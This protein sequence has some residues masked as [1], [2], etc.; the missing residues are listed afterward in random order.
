MHSV[1]RPQKHASHRQGATKKYVR[2][3]RLPSRVAHLSV[4][5]LG[6][7][8]LL[9]IHFTTSMLVATTCH[10]TSGHR[11]N[12]GRIINGGK[13]N[14]TKHAEVPHVHG[15]M[16]SSIAM[17]HKIMKENNQQHPPRRR[18]PNVRTDSLFTL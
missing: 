7:D 18:K 12:H 4:H 13:S 10:D 6:T 11:Q 14:G 5:P 16:T 1:C 9:G 17:R 3:I 2:T 8:F 15:V